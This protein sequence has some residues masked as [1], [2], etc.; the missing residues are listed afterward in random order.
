MQFSPGRGRSAVRQIER[1]LIAADL[2]DIRLESFCIEVMIQIGDECL[3]IRV[4][5]VQGRR[6]L[7]IAQFREIIMCDPLCAV[8][9]AVLRRDEVDPSFRGIFRQFPRLRRSQRI[10]TRPYLRIAF[11]GV[12]ESLEIQEHLIVFQVLQQI[13]D[14]FHRID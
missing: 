13:D 12:G 4:K 5:Q 3:R 10:S 6:S 7:G 2:Q 1:R 9:E 11:I 8:A 14:T